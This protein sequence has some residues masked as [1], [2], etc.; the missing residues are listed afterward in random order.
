MSAVT[1]IRPRVLPQV[2]GDLIKA[3]IRLNSA[4]NQWRAA[5]AAKQRDAEDALEGDTQHWTSEVEDRRTEALA[6]LYDVTGCT[7]DDFLKAVAQ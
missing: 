2:L 6:M 7:L 3:K 1:Q 4:Q 5:V